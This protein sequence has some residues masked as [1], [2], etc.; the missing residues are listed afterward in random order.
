MDGKRKH[1]ILSGLTRAFVQCRPTHLSITADKNRMYGY[2]CRTVHGRYFSCSVA[3]FGHRYKTR[4]TY[5]EVQEN[6]KK[7]EI[8]VPRPVQIIIRLYSYLCTD[9]QTQNNYIINLSSKYHA[10]DIVII[11]I[12]NPLI[13]NF[14]NYLLP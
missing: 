9:L 13:A 6:S 1:R 12:R 11:K 8:H 14:F 2:I 5:F 4:K 3:H 10:A 7:F